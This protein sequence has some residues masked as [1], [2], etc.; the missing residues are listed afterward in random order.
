V[1]GIYMI[2][3]SVAQVIYKRG[4]PMAVVSLAFGGMMTWIGLAGIAAA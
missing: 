4:V 1:F 2:G 3:A